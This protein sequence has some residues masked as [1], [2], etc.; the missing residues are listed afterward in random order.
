M[1]PQSMFSS[2]HALAAVAAIGLFIGGTASAEDSVPVQQ[3]GGDAC[4]VTSG[5]YKGQTGNYTNGGGYLMCSGKGFSVPCD[6]KDGVKQCKSAS[7]ARSVSQ[8][9]VFKGDLYVFTR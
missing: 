4:T 9:P 5:A 7:K 3:Q 6:L 8:L 1:N 2:L